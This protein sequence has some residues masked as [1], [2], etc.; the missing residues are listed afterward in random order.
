MEISG[1]KRSVLVISASRPRALHDAVIEVSMRPACA[2]I[3]YTMIAT[4]RSFLRAKPVGTQDPRV[5]NAT[6]YTPH[7]LGAY[8]HW[9]PLRL[10]LY[11]S[12]VRLAFL[13][14][15]QQMSRMCE[16]AAKLRTPLAIGR[17]RCAN[18][19]SRIDLL[20]RYAAPYGNVTLA[21]YCNTPP[22]INANNEMTSLPFTLLAKSISSSAVSSLNLSWFPDYPDNFYRIPINLLKVLLWETPRIEMT[23]KLRVKSNVILCFRHPPNDIYQNSFWFNFLYHRYNFNCRLNAENSWSR[24]ANLCARIPKN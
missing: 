19:C 5:G 3:I 8:L 18:R 7:A 2:L 17:R 12:P 4:M 9:S 22:A 6:R 16:A 21:R 20:T 24:C 23:T 15:V 13:S 10:S 1:V 14:S 11:A